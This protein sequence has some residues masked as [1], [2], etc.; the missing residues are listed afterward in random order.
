MSRDAEDALAACAGGFVVCVYGTIRGAIGTSFH[1]VAGRPDSATQHPGST[2]LVNALDAAC[3]GA[4]RMPVDAVA[5]S[6]V[7]A[8]DSA[9]AGRAVRGPPN[10]VP[11]TSVLAKEPGRG[12]A[13]RQA[14]HAVTR[15][16]LAVDSVTRVANAIQ[17]LSVASSLR[18]KG[19]ATG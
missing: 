10:P 5:G 3:S 12:R 18:I 2:A 13:V 1:P 14:V 4:S 15:R 9:G 8:A 19:G 16:A 7:V 6:R 17:P 11:A